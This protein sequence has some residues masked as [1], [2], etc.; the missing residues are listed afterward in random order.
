MQAACYKLCCKVCLF[1]LVGADIHQ[2]SNEGDS[3]LYLATFGI[4]NSPE[5]D[6]S[7]IKLLIQAGQYII[8]D[9]Y[10]S[11]VILIDLGLEHTAMAAIGQCL[12]LPVHSLKKSSEKSVGVVH[13]FNLAVN[14]KCARHVG[15]VQQ[16][17]KILLNSIKCLEESQQCPAQLLN[18]LFHTH[19]KMCENESFCSWLC[20][21]LHE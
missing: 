8:N 1:A 20:S 3:A 16:D 10:S 9:N 13:C 14:T 4:L 21:W 7:L 6:V 5:P 12:K 15:H 11:L 19:L 17:F 18:I 2:K